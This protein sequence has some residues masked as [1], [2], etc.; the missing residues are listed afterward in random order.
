M[1]QYIIMEQYIPPPFSTNIPFYTW[2]T[3]LCVS[4]GNKIWNMFDFQWLSLPVTIIKTNKHWYCYVCVFGWVYLQLHPWKA[5][6][7]P[8]LRKV[9]MFMSCTVF[10]VVWN[11]SSCLF[12]G[13]FCWLIRFLEIIFILCINWK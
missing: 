7:K 4:G 11:E 8:K 6:L 5:R 3:V 10:A 13:M 1:E 9:L 2:S 12:P